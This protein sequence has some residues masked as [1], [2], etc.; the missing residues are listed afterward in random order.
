MDITTQL[1]ER[2][3]TFVDQRLRRRLL[4][5][6]S[7]A[8]GAVGASPSL[9]SAQ[10]GTIVGRVTDSRSGQGVQNVIIQIEGTRFAT[11]TNVEGR[12]RLTGVPVGSQTV[13][14]R[15]I[16]YSAAKKPV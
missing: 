4:I 9:V 16:G 12:Y 13:A 8:L 14:A 3:R 15:R 11:G 6:A 2:M 10:T 7:M 5:L 1:E